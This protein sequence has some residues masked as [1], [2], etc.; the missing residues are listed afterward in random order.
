MRKKK[1]LRDFSQCLIAQV[2]KKKNFLNSAG[3]QWEYYAFKENKDKGTRIIFKI[4]EIR[5][6]PVL[7]V[8]R[9]VS[10]VEKSNDTIKVSRHW[11]ARIRLLSPI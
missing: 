11:V 5:G 10:E 4:K 7:G 1:E 8:N 3:M 6:I 9:F 2:R